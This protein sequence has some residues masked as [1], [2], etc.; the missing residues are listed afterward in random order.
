MVAEHSSPPPGLAGFVRRHDILLQ[1]V[2][3]GAAEVIWL[4]LILAAWLKTRIPQ[5]GLLV[6]LNV[7]TA[8]AALALRPKM[9][10]ARSGILWILRHWYP[11]LYY[12]IFFM[13]TGI[14]VPALN[15]RTYDAQLRAADFALFG[16]DPTVALQRFHNPFLTEFLQ[17]CYTSYYFL[18]LIA[19]AGL[20]RYKGVRAFSIALCTISTGFYLSYLCY[21]FVPA[22]GPR[23]EI[24]HSVPLSGVLTFNFIHNSLAGAEGRMPDCFPSGHTAITLLTL[25]FAWKAHRKVF[26]GILPFATGLIVSTVYLRYHYV[27]DLIA[28]VPF[29]ALTVAVAVPLI[30]AWARLRDETVGSVDS[31]SG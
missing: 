24:P 31:A 18:P 13:E 25:W 26:W 16:C 5:A 30:R 9:I 20:I 4:A 27:V 6:A 12:G 8:A 7:S 1:E 10:E 23:F 17:I 3:W 21:F 11:V 28:A 15:S 22:V 29:I 2:L 14:L 19:G